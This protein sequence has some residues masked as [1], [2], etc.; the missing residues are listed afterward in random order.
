MP[1]TVGTASSVQDTI[2]DQGKSRTSS[3]SSTNNFE[4]EI[5]ASLKESSRLSSADIKMQLHRL[6]EKLQ[7]MTIFLL[8]LF[9]CYSRYC[10]S[11]R[12]YFLTD[13]HLRRF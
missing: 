3:Y 13:E 4:C 11:K 8:F 6:G 2:K 10:A 5:A 12:C 9:A 7:D 1:Q